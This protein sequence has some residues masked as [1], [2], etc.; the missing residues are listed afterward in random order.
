MIFIDGM[1]EAL[2][3]TVE[4]IL[5]IFSLELISAESGEDEEAEAR[6]FDNLLVSFQFGKWQVY[7]YLLFVLIYVPC[8]AVIATAHR[9]LGPLLGFIMISYLT[10]LGWAIAVLFYQIIIGGSL[11]IGTA[12]AVLIAI[13]LFFFILRK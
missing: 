10:V 2:S 5:G 4:N 8:V 3:V 6:L 13:V 11:L 1:K 12:V 9:E 7:A